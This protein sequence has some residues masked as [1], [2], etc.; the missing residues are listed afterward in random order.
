MLAKLLEAPA[1]KPMVT[2][3]SSTDPALSYSNI[4]GNGKTISLPL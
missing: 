3:D 4:D 1:I 2:D